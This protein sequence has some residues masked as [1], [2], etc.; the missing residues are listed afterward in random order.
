[1]C[2]KYKNNSKIYQQIRKTRLAP[3]IRIK[4]LPGRPRELPGDLLSF[5]AGGSKS[6]WSPP[7]G[8]PKSSKLAKIAR[9]VVSKFNDFSGCLPEASPEGSG[10]PKW[11]PKHQN[12]SKITPDKGNCHL[13]KRHEFL[14]EQYKQ[15]WPRKQIFAEKRE[16]ARTLKILIFLWFL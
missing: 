13:A 12:W 3:P 8:T 9:N 1:M 14:V 6:I 4:V 15:I 2:K 7:G 16:K 5:G 10:P 11:P